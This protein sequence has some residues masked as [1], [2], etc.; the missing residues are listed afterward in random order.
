MDNQEII[1][2]LCHTLLVFY[3]QQSKQASSRDGLRLQLVF[4]L[5]REGKPMLFH[6]L[7]RSSAS[8]LSSALLSQGPDLREQLWAQTTLSGLSGKIVEVT[9]IKK[10]V[11]VSC[12]VYL[13]WLSPPFIVLELSYNCVSC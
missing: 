6:S 11:T 10:I 1:K 4:M 12:L 13:S 5:H 8:A 2:S 3:Q 9:E 7:S